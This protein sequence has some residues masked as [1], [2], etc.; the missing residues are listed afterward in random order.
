MVPILAMWHERGSHALT[1]LGHNMAGLS[2]L[3]EYWHSF[4]SL[5]CPCYLYASYVSG[6]NWSKLL[7]VYFRYRPPRC[8]ITNTYGGV[9]E[10]ITACYT[11]CSILGSVSYHIAGYFC[12]VQMFANFARQHFTCK[13]FVP[14]LLPYRKILHLAKLFIMTTCFTVNVSDFDLGILSMKKQSSWSEVAIICW[15]L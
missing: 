3:C 5:P 6:S 13:N 2:W 10:Y 4:W 15:L 1:N 14:S 12:E 8:I 11:L 9:A 7:C